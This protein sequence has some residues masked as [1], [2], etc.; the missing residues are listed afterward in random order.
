MDIKQVVNLFE[1]I[2]FFAAS[3]RPAT[4]A[5]ISKHFQWPRSST[6]NLVTTLVGR[7]YL[8]EPRSREGYYPT[9]RWRKIVNRID[10][11]APLPGIHE[12]LESLAQEFEETVVLG[13]LS[14]QRVVFLDVVESQHAVRYTA[15]V[16]KTIPLALTATGRA[17]LSQLTP[18]TRRTI[19]ARTEYIKY[20][21]MTLTNATEVEDEIERSLRRGWFESVSEF[22]PD[23]SGVVQPMTIANR[24]LAVLIG[25]PISR[26][27][28]RH[29]EIALAMKARIKKY[30]ARSEAEISGLKPDVPGDS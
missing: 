7:G 14:G 29:E 6:F 3:Q 21:P 9:T 17:L 30:V 5:E 18:E 26:V 25:G 10:E 27:R 20:T 15:S 8:Y 13:A 11:G 12:L 1:L 16:G 24:Q 23:L 22:S 4:L 19:L 28:H 2:E